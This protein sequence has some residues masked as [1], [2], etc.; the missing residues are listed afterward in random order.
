[1]RC[2]NIKYIKKEGKMQKTISWS[3]RIIFVAILLFFIFFIVGNIILGISEHVPKNVPIELEFWPFALLLFIIFGL[4]SYIVSWFNSKL[5]VK[6]L[7][8]FSFI[9][10]ISALI[11]PMQHKT[12]MI[13]LMGGLF[14]LAAIVNW[15]LK[16]KKQS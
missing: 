4:V 1:M 14:I 13:P 10:A 11:L 9:I 5:A 8:I 15:A 2:D 3:L 12:R 16:R 6:L 7:M